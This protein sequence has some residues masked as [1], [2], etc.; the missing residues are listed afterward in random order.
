MNRRAFVYGTLAKGATTMS[1]SQSQTQIKPTASTPF[2]PQIAVHSVRVDGID[3][4]YREAGPKDGPVLLLLH[5]FPTS[6]FQYRE[7]MALLADKYR[8]IAPDL[9]GFGFTQIP[10]SRGLQVQ[11]RKSGCNHRR[12]H[13]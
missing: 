4:F 10:A 2:I 6:S 8:V 13:A 1:H 12:V 7:L 5:G 11:L 3:V 9:P